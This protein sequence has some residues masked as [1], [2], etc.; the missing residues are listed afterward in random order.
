MTEYITHRRFKNLALC[1]E[2]IN[3]P[4]GTKLFA[5]G[6]FI[7]TKDKKVICSVTSL[8]AHKHFAINDDDRGLERGKLTYAIAY[9]NRKKICY[10]YDKQQIFCRFSEDEQEMLKKEYKYFLKDHDNIVFNHDFYNA[11]LEELQKLADAL[12]IKV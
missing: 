6:N 9:S 8:N 5:A 10:T 11:D 12:K 3:L 2:K 4:Y 7:F 1:G